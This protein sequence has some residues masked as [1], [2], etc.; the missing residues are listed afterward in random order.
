VCCWLRARFRHV[1]Y[2]DV[3][4]C[5]TTHFVGIAEDERGIEE[6]EVFGVLS[7]AAVESR[8]AENARLEIRWS[9][10]A[11]AAL[12]D[13][14]RPGASSKTRPHQ[15]DLYRYPYPSVMYH[16]QPCHPVQKILTHG[17]DCTLLGHAPCIQLHKMLDLTLSARCVNDPCTQP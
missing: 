16:V 10:L 6:R 17:S 13:L 11:D 12:L 3:L 14:Y 5:N 15:S 4:D 1:A 9:R 8:C 7:M 2:L